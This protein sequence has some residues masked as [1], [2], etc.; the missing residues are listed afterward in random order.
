MKKHILSILLSLNAF[1]I[2]FSSTANA[3]S[4]DNHEA[5]TYYQIERNGEVYYQ[6]Y[7]RNG[8]P[9]DIGYIYIMNEENAKPDLDDAVLLSELSPE[10]ELDASIAVNICQNTLKKYG[11]VYFSEEY[12]ENKTGI[13][14]IINL[15]GYASNDAWLL[16]EIQVKLNVQTLDE[17]S[18]QEDAILNDIFSLLPQ[19]EYGYKVN[20]AEDVDD[21]VS[22]KIVSLA[23]AENIETDVSRIFTNGTASICTSIEHWQAL[24]ELADMISESEYV[25][26]AH[27]S[28]MGTAESTIC[29]INS[30]VYDSN[31]IIYDVV[32][33]AAPTNGDYN[34]DGLLEISDAQNLL[35]YSAAHVAGT[36]ESLPIVS[37]APENMDV[38]GDGEITIADAQYVLTYCAQQAA[39]LNPTWEEILK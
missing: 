39:G 32:Y 4:L 3:L 6:L 22:I 21:G 9:T 30:S 27:V 34:N 17:Y 29:T 2:P 35:A 1:A 20:T 36:T 26:H 10:T 25:S 24:L 11:D 16:P 33:S 23:Y 5:Q 8:S 31:E 14:K 19:D 38:D 18:E 28:K 13:D 12:I 37:S 15:K 7:L